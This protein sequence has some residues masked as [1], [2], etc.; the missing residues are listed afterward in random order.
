MFDYIREGDEPIEYKGKCHDLAAN[1]RNRFTD[2]LILAD[3]M[4]PHEFLIEALSLHLYAEYVSSR[5]AKSSVWV[6]I[7]T[8]SRLAMRMGYH[9]PSQPTLKSTPFQVR[10]LTCA[11]V[12]SNRHEDRDAS[13]GLGFC[14]SS[15][16]HDFLPD[17]PALDDLGKLTRDRSSTQYPR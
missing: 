17:G 13:P 12:V 1:F 3:Y 8:I 10:Q 16:Y 7:G 5:D 6:L 2:C 4:Q 9:Q 11:R 14:C 15:R